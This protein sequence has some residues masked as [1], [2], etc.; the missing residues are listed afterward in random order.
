MRC[1]VWT[2]NFSFMPSGIRNQLY[3]EHRTPN[4]THKPLHP[5]TSYLPI[6]YTHPPIMKWSERFTWYMSSAP[7]IV[8]YL[9]HCF[10]AFVPSQP[11]Q[12]VCI[13]LNL[14]TIISNQYPYNLIVRHNPHSLSFIEIFFFILVWLYNIFVLLLQYI[15]PKTSYI[16]TMNWMEQ[17]F[18]ENIYIDNWTLNWNIEHATFEYNYTS[19]L[20]NFVRPSMNIF[21]TKFVLAVYIASCMS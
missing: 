4:L 12:L 14:N 9:W 1:R 16:L 20:Y 10:I 3:I 13:Q 11:H 8:R 18:G 7:L 21:E 17:N 6:R 5:R 19:F 2:S 15:L